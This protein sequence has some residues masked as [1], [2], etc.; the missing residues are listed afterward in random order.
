MSSVHVGRRDRLALAASVT[1]VLYFMAV[2]DVSPRGSYCD[3]R[4]LEVER[5]EYG[6]SAI[7]AVGLDELAA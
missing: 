2:L 5:L 3:F 7:H 1:V 6:I 4:R